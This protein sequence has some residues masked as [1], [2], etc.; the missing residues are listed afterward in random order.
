M[1]IIDRI[2]GQE[3]VSFWWESTTAPAV[4]GLGADELYRTQANLRAVISFIADN[5]ADL[6]LKVYDRASDTDRPRVTDSVAAQLI[7]RPNA[8]T[9]TY[10]FV[11]AL[12]STIALYDRAFVLV[13]EDRK[14]ESGWQMRL[15]PDAWIAKIDGDGWAPS[16]ITIRTQG[17]GDV[18]VTAKDFIYFHGFSPRSPRMGCSPVESLRSTLLEQVEAA[19]YRSQIWRRGGRVGMYITRPKD[20]RSWDAE[21]AKKWAV[22][23]RDAFTGDA[24]SQSGG[25]P[26][27]E[28]GMDIKTIQLNAKEAQWAESM[29]L[30]RSEVAAAY[31]I[32]PALIWH[33]QAQT[34][35]SAKD[36]ARSLY[37]ESLGPWLTMIAQRLN[38]FLLPLI[39][40]EPSHYVEFDIRRKLEGSFE[41]RAQ[42]IQ[43]SVGAPWMT[44]NEA[45]A[46]N[47]LPAIEGGDELI[48]PLN[49]LEGGLASPTDTARDNYNA[50]EPDF[51]AFPVCDH[52]KDCDAWEHTV[53]EIDDGGIAEAL[54]EELH[55]ADAD[56]EIKGRPSEEIEAAYTDVYKRFFERQARSVLSRIAKKDATEADWWD[57]VRWTRELADDLEPLTRKETEA[58]AR[59]IFE[60]LGIDPDLY[61]VPLT[62]KYIR[63]LCESRAQAANEKMYQALLENVE[64]EEPDPAAIYEE[65]APILSERCGRSIAAA[66]LSFAVM[67]GVQQ[68]I[69]NGASPSQVTKTWRVNSAHPRS[70]HAAMAGE[71]V[72]YDQKFSN[73]AEWPQDPSLPA[74]EAVNCMCTVDVRVRR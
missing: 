44:R 51:K 54:Q 7:K 27:L 43:S 23:F 8:D 58:K 41:E 53:C 5:V 65:Q 63:T 45:R 73:G 22:Q 52:W 50:A 42:V 38:Q 24:G 39:G 60:A 11:R 20:V 2:R 28:D 19:R 13:A 10:E 59:E 55:T 36:N 4:L 62:A 68:G 64:S 72:P 17:V 47:N 21:T 25:V 74:A 26:V 71:T 69:N 1:S 32:N 46:M 34:Y 66:A 29:Q 40:E 9:T 49:V 37:A 48:V 35:A 67:E 16:S 31:H 3:K 12:V 70:S 14:A 30:S 56:V 15:L 6:P 57:A 33:D 18:T 61:S